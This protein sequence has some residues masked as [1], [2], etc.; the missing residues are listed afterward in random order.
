MGTDLKPLP[1]VNARFGGVHAA[2]RWILTG[3]T[4]GILLLATATG[5]TATAIDEESPWPRVRSTNG[6][7]VTLHLP[8]VESWTSNSFRA[9]AAVEVKQAKA[10]NESKKQR[11]PTAHNENEMIETTEIQFL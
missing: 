10:K 4:P 9:R 1:S 5:V 2:F 6:Y 8:Q 3:C 11:H 7:T